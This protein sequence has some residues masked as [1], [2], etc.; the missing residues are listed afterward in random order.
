M[1][2]ADN[3]NR[4]INAK[5]AIRQAIIDKG[6]EVPDAEKLDTY[7]S[8]ID[9]IGTSKTPLRMLKA[10]LD[11]GTAETDYP[12]GTEIADEY[13]GADAPLIVAYYGEATLP[14]GT[15]TQGVYLFRSY[16]LFSRRI[17]TNSDYAASE[18]NSYL[19]DEYINSCSTDLNE[20]ATEISVPF[21]LTT[22]NYQPVN[23]KHFLMSATELA[24]TSS[25]IEGSVWPVWSVR[26]GG[27]GASQLN[28]GRIVK[29]NDGVAQYYWTRTVGTGG[30]ICVRPDGYTY[31]N[32]TNAPG[33]SY[34]IVPACF[35]AK[36][37]SAPSDP[38]GDGTDWGTLYTTQ[39]P[40][41][42]VLNDEADFN[43]LGNSNSVNSYITINGHSLQ[44]TTLRRYSF[45][46]L[47]K[48]VP[49]NFLSQC[50]GMTQIIGVGVIKK[51]GNNFLSNLVSLSMD[52]EVLDFKNLEEIGSYFLSGCQKLNAEVKIPKVKIIG[53]AFMISNFAYTQPLT[54][55]SSVETIG[56][57][58]L[59]Y[60]QDFTGLLTVETSAT[61]PAN[62]NYSIRGQSRDSA[63][64]TQGVRITGA[65]A[66]AWK[67]ALP[68]SSSA[69]R[70]LIL[71][72]Q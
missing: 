30:T 24:G 28:A 17:G 32:T 37:G 38:E 7:H 39:Y 8:Y 65:G 54:I 70:K 15:T 5:T 57:N 45:G 33:T 61:P 25:V 47:C 26:G 51:I 68:D 16:A 22:T 4:I 29:N 50:M 19:N 31:T 1:S 64:Y 55:P 13:D 71:V 9:Q 62:D 58:F 60:I 53:N 14:N 6:V 63:C 43:K 10:S 52:G 2:I 72:E 27:T 69:Y 46:K 66:S 49:D 34:G 41:G 12:I 44:K 18:I 36:S 67:T 23:A 21:Y 40:D 20:L 56:S 11:A 48:T 42:L 35:I 59:S 3:L